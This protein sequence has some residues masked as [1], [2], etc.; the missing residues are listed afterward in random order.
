VWDGDHGTVTTQPRV[1][2]PTDWD[3][4]LSYWGVDPEKFAVVEPVKFTAYHGWAR[5]EQGEDAVSAIRWV[6]RSGL[7]LH[8]P[9]IDPDYDKLISEIRSHKKAPPKPSDTGAAFL[10]NLA[11]WQLGKRDG[12]GT[13]GIVHRCLMLIDKVQHRV[14]ALRKSGVEL[15]T[16]YVAGLG[17][18][19]E[20]CEG[21]YPMQAFDVELDRRQQVK[22]ARRLL[23]KM[24]TAW[25]PLFGKVVVLAVPGNHGEH[26]SNG[27]AF[28]TFGD[29]DDTAVFEQVAEILGESDS[30]SHVS[31]VIPDSELTVTLDLCGTVVGFAH[32]HQATRGSSI[33][34]KIEG[35]WKGQQ[36]GRHP[37]GD[38]DILVTAHYHHFACKA[39]AGRTWLQCPTLDGGSEWFEHQSGSRTTPGT[40][41]LVVGNGGWNSLEI[42]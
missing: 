14:G 40:L 36:H 32:G 4:E 31:F 16:L 13:E 17:D 8:R 21:H 38:A 7:R 26:R 9:D 11:D 2:A 41:T 28:T 39:D 1:E 22:V 29:N 19:V 12:D 34:Q 15:S 35:W 20:G 37:I 23:V 27:E 18:L 25:A 3:D 10:V 30:Y 24:I 42:L 6:F 33:P 5:T